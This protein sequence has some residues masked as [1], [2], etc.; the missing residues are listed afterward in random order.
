MK[1]CYLVGWKEQNVWY[2]GVR[3]ARGCDPSDLMVSYFTSSKYVHECIR[4][5]GLP[6]VIQ[7]R[8]T[9][10]KK[11]PALVWEQKVL[12]RMKVLNESKW[13]NKN[14]SGAIN[15]DKEIREKMSL[16]KLGR[17]WVYN[18]DGKIMIDK[19]LEEQYLANGYKRGHGQD[20]TGIRN[21]MYGKTHSNSTRKSISAARMGVNTNT[22]EGIA[23]KKLRFDNDNPMHD[24]IHKEKWRKSR[25]SWKK[26]VTN[27]IDIFNS[28]KEAA[29]ASGCSSS[30]IHYRIK[31]GRS[32]WKYCA[33]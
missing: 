18:D 30:T 6:D 12:R 1:Y 16:K 5:W 24:P 31:N 17:A 11:H 15:F 8:K 4:N 19:E 26:K 20:Q 32:P 13:L 23:A 7:V 14:I 25:E 33:V 9:F 21:P 29:E 27:G 10:H 2:Y 22:P 28:M 3:Y